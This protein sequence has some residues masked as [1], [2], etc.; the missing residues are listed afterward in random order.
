MILYSKHT[1]RICHHVANFSLFKPISVTYYGNTYQD[2]KKKDY[3]SLKTVRKLK[4]KLFTHDMWLDLDDNNFF[5]PLKLLVNF[6]R[7]QP[8]IRVSDILVPRYLCC[9][10]SD[11]GHLCISLE[12]F[13][14]VQNNWVDT[15]PGRLALSTLN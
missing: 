5:F 10:E 12:Y 2:C 6:K 8:S 1:K 11:R 14:S 13:S 9:S 7:S 4:T 15:F 3:F